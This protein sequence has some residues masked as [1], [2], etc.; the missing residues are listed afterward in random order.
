MPSSTRTPR[1]PVNRSAS[2]WTGSRCSPCCAPWVTQPCH[3]VDGCTRRVA[4]EAH[5]PG[6][7]GCRCRCADIGCLN[8]CCHHGC[9]WRLQVQ[10]QRLADALEHSIINDG[11]Q[12]FPKD[13]AADRCFLLRSGAVQL[14]TSDGSVSLLTAGACIGERA[15]VAGDNRCILQAQ[16]PGST[17]F[18]L[19][20][21]IGSAV[22]PARL[23]LL[24]SM[25]VRRSR[26]AKPYSYAGQGIG[27]LG[28]GPGVG[29]QS[30]PK[31]GQ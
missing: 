12:L 30:C 5:Q 24:Y 28:G 11:Q 16:A 10:K 7:R 13:R 3:D 6:L 4:V 31:C 14:T 1:P 8:V 27:C 29:L 26:T 23:L 21:S 18:E 9:I 20:H 2:C 19:E 25:H 15:L 22:Q 17:L